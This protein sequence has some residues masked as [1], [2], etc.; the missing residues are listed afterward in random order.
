MQ[1]KIPYAQSHIKRIQVFAS[2][3]FQSIFISCF[4]EWIDVRTCDVNI[5]FRTYENDRDNLLL[6]FQIV[7]HRPEKQEGQLDF[8]TMGVKENK[9]VLFTLINDN[10]VTVS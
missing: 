10:P 2:F 5:A 9:S 6:S 3:F 7:P 4:N 8:G 1:N